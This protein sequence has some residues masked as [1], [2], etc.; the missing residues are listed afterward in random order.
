MGDIDTKIQAAEN[1][2][3]E[4]LQAA[5]QRLGQ[6]HDKVKDDIWSLAEKIAEVVAINTGLARDVKNNEKNLDEFKESARSH[7][8]ILHTKSDDLEKR[9]RTLEQK[10]NTKQVENQKPDEKETVTGFKVK[11]IWGL[12]IVAVNS[13][14]TAAVAWM[15]AKATGRSP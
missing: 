4:K 13:A 5:E 14:I 7:H 9:V 11:I 1:R 6:K 2:L 3:N 12:I 15:V 10:K 8:S